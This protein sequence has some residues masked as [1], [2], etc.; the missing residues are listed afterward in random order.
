[1]DNDNDLENF[2]AE[3]S[4]RNLQKKIFDDQN[5]PFEFVSL[6]CEKFEKPR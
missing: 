5:V 2:V 3:S 1:V 4:N 6:I